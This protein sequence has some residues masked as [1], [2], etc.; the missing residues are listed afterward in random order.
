MRS[1]RL[2]GETVIGWDF[3]GAHAKACLVQGAV[4]RDV[5]QW[6][7]PLW[8]GLE[9]LEQV[10]EQARA[11][12]HGA[13]TAGWHAATMTGEMVDLFDDREQGVRGIA[14]AAQ[15]VLGTPRLRFY[16]GRHGWVEAPDAAARWEHIASANWLATAAWVARRLGDAVLVDIG[17]T[18]TDIIPVRAGVVAFGSGEAVDEATGDRPSEVTGDAQRLRSGALV[19]Q[20]VVRTPLCALTQ[21]VGFGGQ[22][23]NVMNEWFATTADVYRLT[24]ELDPAHD[25]QPAADNGAR[26]C[27][28]AAR[29][30]AR[31]IGRDAREAP[32]TQWQAF[33]RQWRAAQLRLVAESL[34]RVLAAA[35]LPDDA[36]LVAAGAGDFLVADLA[37]Q[38]GRPLVAF[39]A[40]VPAAD[41]AIAAA[42]AVC[43]PAAAVA[44]LRDSEGRAAAA[45]AR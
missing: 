25:L 12:W 26:D 3:G 43:A 34:D 30:L 27:E 39:D 29:R 1:E 22:A 17:S 2:P 11:A 7:C 15:A 33:A 28:G 31:M 41:A 38:A 16:A 21:R 18:T 24:G 20:G 35:G 36:P 45:E 5:R 42:A 32:L 23:Y 4:V 14:A 10:L 44:L 9:H 19:Y 8:K 37:R 6:V 13:F 40:L